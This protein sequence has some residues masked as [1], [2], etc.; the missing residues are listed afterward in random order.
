MNARR[1]FQAA[2]LAVLLWRGALPAMMSV[3]PGLFWVEQPTRDAEVGIVPFHGNW[4]VITNFTYSRDGKLV[5]GDE[6]GWIAP[7]SYLS[8]NGLMEIQGRHAE[9][10][11]CYTSRLFPG[12][13]VLVAH[14][15]LRALVGNWFSLTVAAFVLGWARGKDRGASAS[16]L[17]AGPA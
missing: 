2:A 13:A 8:V 9:Y 16:V 15:P 5:H 7:E 3:A 14:L 10:P 11:T 12:T 6:Y 4:S 17:P 1:V